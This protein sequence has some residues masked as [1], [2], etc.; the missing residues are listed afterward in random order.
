MNDSIIFLQVTAVFENR[1]EVDIGARISRAQADAQGGWVCQ[2]QL[3]PV[4]AEPVNV[5]GVDSFHATWLA[6]S[7]VLKLLGHL[8]SEGVALR[9]LDGA[10]FPLEAYLS[11]LGGGPGDAAG[12]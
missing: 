4:H 9:Q 5:R 7:L 10:E 8:K 2:V 11:G 6:L 1:R 3:S 12:G